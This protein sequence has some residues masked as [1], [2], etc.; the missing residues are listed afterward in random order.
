MTTHKSVR[1]SVDGEP[2][3]VPNPLTVNG[4]TITP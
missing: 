2:V 1:R 4:Q 3:L